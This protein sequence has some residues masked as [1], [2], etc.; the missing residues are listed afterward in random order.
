MSTNCLGPLLGATICT[1]PTMPCCPVR[2][3]AARMYTGWMVVA[4]LVRTWRPQHKKHSLSGV[5]MAWWVLT[6]LDSTD[7]WGLQRDVW[8][9]GH[10]LH[11]L[12]AQHLVPTNY[13]PGVGHKCGLVGKPQASRIA[14]DLGWSSRSNADSRGL[15]LVTKCLGGHHRDPW[16]E[17]AC[18]RIQRIVPKLAICTTTVPLWWLHKETW[19]RW[20]LVQ[21]MPK[22]KKSG[23]HTCTASPPLQCSK[24]LDSQKEKSNLSLHC[25]S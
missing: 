24:S 10:C 15:G 22:A 21:Q 11:V 17:D 18:R 23:T 7:L 5:Q 4:L 3:A 13:L 16:I 19:K 1:L 25:L 20:Q 9:E 6:Q 8:L 12:Q 14:D 2:G